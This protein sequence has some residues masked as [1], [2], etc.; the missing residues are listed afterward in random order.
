MTKPAPLSRRQMLEGLTLEPISVKPDRYAPNILVLNENYSAETACCEPGCHWKPP[1]QADP[2]I[3]A[4]F[5]TDRT[6][7]QTIAAWYAA[8]RYVSQTG[9]E[10][11]PTV[12]PSHSDTR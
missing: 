6:G 7:H 4:R 10:K 8:D 9:H 11:S 1:G 12:S 3:S 2:G 5:H